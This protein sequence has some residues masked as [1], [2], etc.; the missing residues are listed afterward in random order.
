MGMKARITVIGM[1]T[2]GIMALGKC[3]KKIMITRL[4]MT[5]SSMSVC[6]KLST[7]R[8]IRSERSYVVTIFR[9]FGR[10]GSMSL[11]LWLTRSI[12]FCASSPNRMMTTP[13]TD[14]TPHVGPEGHCGHVLHQH[15]RAGLRVRH[16]DNV[17]DVV[18]RLDVAA[19]P[20]H[21]FATGHLDQTG[22]DI[23]VA[24]A[25]GVHDHVDRNLVTE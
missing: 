1:V 7:E 18:E 4:T 9:P 13:P 14:A 23:V 24:L 5:S 21:I 8:S 17:A 22:A 25:K 15:R 12:T 16:D 3:H 2:M 10:V 19:S 11:I 6:F 20:H